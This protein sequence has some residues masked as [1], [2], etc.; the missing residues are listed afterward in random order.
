MWLLQPRNVKD[1][2]SLVPYFYFHD[3][4]ACCL[5]MHNVIM[6]FPPA[7]SLSGTLKII[8]QWDE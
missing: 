1:C 4:P 7:L 5:L 2:N 3:K 6:N 8:G